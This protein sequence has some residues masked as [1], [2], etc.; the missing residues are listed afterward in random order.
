MLGGSGF[1]VAWLDMKTPEMRIL[2]GIGSQQQAG[3]GGGG[4]G[5]RWAKTKTTLSQTLLRLCTGAVAGR[6]GGGVGG[7][8]RQRHVSDTN[9]FLPRR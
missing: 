9:S 6:G 7:R 1:V 4:V 8:G 5:G 2:G 3:V